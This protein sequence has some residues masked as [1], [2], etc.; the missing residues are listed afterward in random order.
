[1]FIQGGGQKWLWFSNTKI[2]TYASLYFYKTWFLKD[3]W[4]KGKWAR[5]A[6]FHCW[7][8]SILRQNADACFSKWSFRNFLPF[9]LFLMFYWS[10]KREHLKRKN[11]IS[12]PF[13]ANNKMPFSV[14]FSRILPPAEP[15]AAHSFCLSFYL[16]PHFLR[17]SHCSFIDILLF[18]SNELL[19]R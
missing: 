16:F 5:S 11:K 15:V 6:F 17:E 12:T 7:L 8:F 10:V 2:Y 3:F 18:I 4:C 1:M 19:P 9:R 14:D 13:F